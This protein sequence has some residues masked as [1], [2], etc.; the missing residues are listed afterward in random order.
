MA[1]EDRVR[2]LYDQL[3]TINEEA[4]A[5]HSFNVAYHTLDA[6]LNCAL[7]LDDEAAIQRVKDIAIA[8]LSWIDQNAPNYKHS[9]PSALVRGHESVFHTLALQAAMQV[10]MV[11]KRKKWFKPEGET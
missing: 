8:Q 11:E 4:F 1:N 9:T 6:A 7:Q 10:E 5:M 3:M 2:Y